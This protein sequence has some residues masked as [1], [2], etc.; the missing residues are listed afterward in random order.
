VE[1][2]IVSI[3]FKKAIPCCFTFSRIFF[4]FRVGLVAE[5]GSFPVLNAYSDKF[6]FPE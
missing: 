4:R 3:E 2:G 6:H 5:L 1:V